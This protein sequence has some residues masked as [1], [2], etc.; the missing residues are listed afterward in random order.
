[1]YLILSHRPR[2]ETTDAT[3]KVNLPTHPIEVVR[4]AAS[5]EAL[6]VNEVDG[7]LES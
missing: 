7:G 4:F 2:T 6:A 1:M 5:D 3:Y